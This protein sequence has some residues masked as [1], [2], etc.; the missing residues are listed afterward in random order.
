[1]SLLNNGS[2][3][4]LGRRKRSNRVDISLVLT[5]PRT[6]GLFSAVAGGQLESAIYQLRPNQNQTFRGLGLSH[7][8]R[9]IRI[10]ST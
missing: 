1:M 7:A 2:I 5:P 4:W 10:E 8:K 6:S 9:Y 3:H